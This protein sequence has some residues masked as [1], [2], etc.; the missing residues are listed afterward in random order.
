MSKEFHHMDIPVAGHWPIY[1]ILSGNTQV[2]LL[3]FHVY[4]IWDKC[5]DYPV[6]IGLTNRGFLRI[7]E[8]FSLN[9]AVSPASGLMQCAQPWVGWTVSFFG[10]INGSKSKAMSTEAQFELRSRP[11]FSCRAWNGGVDARRDNLSWYVRQYLHLG[12]LRLAVSNV[13]HSEQKRQDLNRRLEGGHQ[14]SRWWYI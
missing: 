6:Y 3:S 5:S 11:W 14:L 13:K 1:E 9:R 2:E 8:H 7:S 12:E 10:P 4:V